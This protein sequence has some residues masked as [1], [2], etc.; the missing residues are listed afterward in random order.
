MLSKEE[1]LQQLNEEQLEAVV[2]LERPTLI[3]AGAGTG[4]TK[5][6]THKIAYILEKDP[7]VSPEQIVMLTFT[8]AAA[9]EMLTRAKQL[10]QKAENVIGGTFHSYAYMML[11]KNKIYPSKVQVIDEDDQ[12]RIFKIILET[13]QNDASKVAEKK[14]QNVKVKIILK[15]DCLRDVYNFLKESN[16]T[17]VDTVVTLIYSGNLPETFIKIFIDNDNEGQDIIE[18]LKFNEQEKEKIEKLA[19]EV[20]S[21]I[22]EKYADYKKTRNM[23]DYCDILVDYRNA[24]VNG[25]IVPNIKYLVVDEYQDVSNIQAEIVFELA[26]HCNNRVTVVG[27][28][29]QSIYSFR[30]A[31]FR[32]IIDFPKRFDN[33]KIVKLERNYRSTFEIL[34]LANQ[35]LNNKARYLRENPD[36][37]KFLYT[38]RNGPSPEIIYIDDYNKTYSYIKNIMNKYSLSHKNTAIISRSGWIFRYFEAKIDV[39]YEKWGGQ[40][41][42]EKKHIKNILAIYSF[43]AEMPNSEI[44]FY[45]FIELIPR[46]G[47]KTAHKLY[48]IVRNKK[49]NKWNVSDLI[50]H[51]LNKKLIQENDQYYLALRLI[52]SLYE[53]Y[54]ENKNIKEIADRV[55]DLFLHLLLGDEGDYAKKADVIALTRLAKSYD[56]IEEMIETITFIESNKNKEEKKLILT[57]VHSAKGLEWDNVFIVG[58]EDGIFP[59]KRALYKMNGFG[60]EALDEE[61]RLFYVAATRAKN[62]LFIIKTRNSYSTILNGIRLY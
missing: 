5:T 32:N 34:D 45:R 25:D 50:Q 11:K 10:N 59:S 26:K 1:T 53:Q 43:I 24:L 13:N 44:S 9:N 7:E 22:F 31:N 38:D 37:K 57:T 35:V 30:A 58:V 23:L 47:E 54:K 28:E 18:Y 4:K 62:R 27:D 33:C 48:E 17:V 36:F 40:R 61:I 46:V 60:N 56:T 6:I 41:F 8:K 20:L 49:D 16:Y 42:F 2:E 19:W 51:M 55:Q 3:L 14:E 15:P 21:S 12:E 39:P 29:A 52:E